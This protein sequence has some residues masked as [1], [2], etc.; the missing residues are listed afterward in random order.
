MD[1]RE[2][3][4]RNFLK[5]SALLG[6]SSVLA[7]CS[8]RLESLTNPEYAGEEYQLDQPE[9]IIYSTCLNCHV[10]CPMKAKLYEGVLIKIDGNPYSP[11]NLL[12]HIPYETSPFDAAYIDGKICVKG[13]ASIQTHYDPYRLRRVLKRSGPRGSNQWK[14]IPF[15]QFIK[16]VVEGGK[17]FADIGE[18]REIP[19]FKDVYK[20]KDPNLAKSMA[21]DVGKIKKKE[22]TVDEFKDK[23]G[24]HLGVLI[25]PDHPDLGPVNN[26]FVFCAGRIEH[27]RKE[28][29][30][31]WTFDSLGSVNFY[32]HTTI[33]EQS[34]HIAY[35]EMTK[36]WKKGK[37]D[38]GRTHMKPDLL[39]ADF[40]I[41][42]G[43][44]AFEANFGP[45]P[46]TE[47]VTKSLRERNFKMAVVDPRLSKTAAKAT[48]WVPIKP[49]GDGD[50]ALGMIRWIIENERYD[51]KFL[52]NANKAAAKADDE[53][54]W[55]NA[56]YLVEIEDDG[57]GGLL[58]IDSKPAVYSDGKFIPV[59]PNDDKTPVEGDLFVD[60][61][62]GEKRVKSALLLLRE[63][64]ESKS[65]KEWA[66]LSGVEPEIIEELSAEFTS[67][68]KKA[69]AELYRGAVQHTNGYYNAQAIISL[70][71]LI[72]NADW[73]GGLSKGGGHWHEFGGKEGNVYHFKKLHPNKLTK[74]G[75]PLTREKSRYEESTL[76]NGYPAKRP[77]YPFSD[78]IY[79][80]IIPSAADAYPYPIKI[81]YLHK[82]TP[83]LATPTGERFIPI[84]Q[85]TEKIP[86]FISCDIV[87]GETSMYADYIIPD[88]TYLERWGTPHVTPDVN[89]ITSKV[90][91]PV[92]APITE[93]VEVDGENMPISMEAFLIAVGKALGLSGIGK[94]GFGDGMDFHRPEDFFL[95]AIANLAYGDKKGEVVPDALDEEMELFGKARGHLPASV[96]SEEKWKRALRPEE[97]RKVVY[98][99]NRG[100][101][102]ESFRKAY[103][104]KYMAH[105]N[106]NILHIYVERVATTKNS[107]TGKRF[108]GIPIHEPIM[109]I[110]G[111]PVDDREYP[112]HLISFK[113]I[114]AGHSR[115]A[116]HY[117]SHLSLLP[118]NKVM[119]NRRD[120]EALGLKEDDRVWLT[121]KSN[122]KGVIDLGNGRVEKMVGRVGI[123][124]GV[125]PGVVGLSWHYGQ[126]NWYGAHPSIAIDGV[127]IDGDERRGKGICPNQLMRADEVLGNVCLTD[128][129]GASASF[130]DTKVKLQKV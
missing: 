11:Q 101:R 88:L 106:K 53:T 67:H 77:W 14:S 115:T 96:F 70:N 102:Y 114:F 48:W 42:F 29:G 127:K 95:K 112:F 118:E 65:I 6:G 130:F 109:D 122:P 82:G 4:R 69:A 104:G 72:G 34:H 15:S 83:A 73:K 32:E 43:T 129:I 10:A 81:L 35:K 74:F 66:D 71:F 45:P 8:K 111:N 30:K 47:K 107:I 93:E 123:I 44:G 41:F 51:K 63:S 24:E 12:Y 105:K 103:K 116:G 31:R 36:S 85:D 79:Q 54:C 108:S 18:E 76:F 26:Q 52:E 68:G 60:T 20:L 38:G 22:M 80:E 113:E 17:L 75:P 21:K 19:G 64:A 125:R 91:Q 13:Q 27:G 121:S 126:W 23:Y 94:D 84:L 37:W 90:R 5:N 28:L 1:S 57:P 97:W 86:L 50:L 25:D 9:N 119:I 117:L 58:K 16:E 78:N 7:A 56:S 89:T 61:T 49:G 46:M 39:N 99:L 98:V 33:C 40:V 120:A 92:V 87:I 55:S 3:N 124:E 2:M 59:D 128:P 110:K 100:G 62:Y